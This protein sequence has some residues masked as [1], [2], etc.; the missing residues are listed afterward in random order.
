MC[1]ASTSTADAL[2]RPICYQ[3]GHVASQYLLPAG[4]GNLWGT[5][6]FKKVTIQTRRELVEALR[7][8]Y[9]ASSREE[10]TRILQE[11]SATTGCHRK[12]AIRIL[13]GVGGVPDQH[14]Q[15]PRRHLYDGAV[16]EALV[17]LWEAADRICGKRLKA[18]PPVLTSALERH[19]HLQV[20]PVVRSK[21]MAMS[22]ATMDR[23]LREVRAN[24]STGRR[25]RVPTALRRRVPI[26]TFDDWNDP[27]PGYMEMDLV[28]HC[29]G[30]AVGSYVH[31]LSATDLFSGWTE[32]V[33]LVVRAGSL[34]IESLET[35]QANLP[36]SLRGLDVDNG[37]EFLNEALVRYCTIR[38][39]ELTRSRPYHSNDQAW[40]EQKNG[41][42][43]RLVGY[44]RHE[45]AA[46]IEVL[47]RLY[48]AS[49]LF[50]NFFQP[51]FKLREK[52]RVGARVIKHYHA[53][54]TP[55]AR[56]LRPASSPTR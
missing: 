32:C 8:R 11:F 38:G 29:G 24:S 55:C 28:A 15:H 35:M 37:G 31:T 51:S 54:E 43:V 7:A 22:A 10:K 56:L 5:T 30:S 46:A 18:I 53:P 16:Q 14:L 3:N 27:P 4:T 40:I 1:L 21:L 13:N 36:F 50:V 44:D 26:R 48:A 41:S 17:V 52:T 19:Q 42:V 39:I 23:S 47:S 34:V 9:G 49:R 45:G 20:E 6:V 2:P 33:P 25:R 12:S